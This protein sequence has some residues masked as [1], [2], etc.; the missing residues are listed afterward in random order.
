M[1]ITLSDLFKS[2]KGERGDKTL[3]AMKKLDDEYVVKNHMMVK[4]V[5]YFFVEKKAVKKKPSA[6]SVA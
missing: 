6:T 4:S 3:M 2:L 1:I 5:D